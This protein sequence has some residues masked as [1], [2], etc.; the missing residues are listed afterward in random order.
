[1][2]RQTYTEPPIVFK[3]IFPGLATLADR[4]AL[5]A[6]HGWPVFPCRADKTPA[7]RHGFKSAATDPAA[8][9]CLFDRR[10]AALIGVP[11]GGMSGF[12]VLDIDAK[13]RTAHDWWNDNRKRLSPRC[14][15]RTRSGGLHVY[16][17]HRD[18][19][20]NS[21]G[22]LALGV[23]VRAEGGYVI[24]WA[25]HGQPILADA[26]LPAWPEWMWDALHPPRP[27]VIQLPNR[28]RNA[29]ADQAIE[30]IILRALYQV[31]TAP[32]GNRHDR[33]RGAA[34][35]IGGLI[36]Q[37]GLSEASEHAALVAA[38]TSAGVPQA[39]AE[40]VVTWG[41]ANGR[42]LPLS[43]GVGGGRSHD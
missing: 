36:D 17:R 28:L 6:A 10:T 40:A 14:A 37:A 4:A 16:Y 43:I 12:V 15:V 26:E 13:S 1:L 11:T 21:Q 7:I 3:G 20:R 31:R 8:V 35:T 32:E 30:R 24:A 9:R 38:G 25:A 34:R 27:T 23:D 42:S 33:L 18:G 29:T 2:S 39:E 19:L 22:R 5:L 41:L